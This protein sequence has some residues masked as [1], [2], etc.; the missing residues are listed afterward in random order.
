MLAAELVGT[1]VEQSEQCARP[2]VRCS[3]PQAGRA[4]VAEL[5]ASDTRPQSVQ[6]IPLKPSWS[7][8]SPV[9][10]DRSK[11]KPTSSNS[12]ADRHAVVRHDLHVPASIAAGRAEVVVEPAARV[13]LL[14]SAG[15]VR[16]VAVLLWAAAGEVLRHRRD[17]VRAEHVAPGTPG[18]YAAPR[19]RDSSASSPK[20]ERPGATTVARWRGRSADGGRRGCRRQ[21]TRGRAMSPKRVHRLARRRS[22]PGRSLGPLRERSGHD[23]GAGLSWNE[24]RGSVET[25][26]GMPRR[27]V[28]A[29]SCR[30][31]C[32]SAI[33][34]VASPSASATAR[35]GFT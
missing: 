12:G 18:R 3:T 28:A 22:Q 8:R 24:C 11:L 26:T 5:R 21:R 32:H 14:P 2:V 33:W 10:T 25:V 1:R 30:R 6:T 27:V 23:R 34:R 4:D 20:V 29:S 13:H 15:E 9:M 31:L 7:R 17:R 16:V 19:R 35:A